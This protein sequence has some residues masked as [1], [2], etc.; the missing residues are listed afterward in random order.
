[1]FKLFYYI[2]RK[3]QKYLKRIEAPVKMCIKLSIQIKPIAKVAICLGLRRPMHIWDAVTS[4]WHSLRENP[5]LSSSPERQLNAPDK[6]STGSKQCQIN[7]C[8]FCG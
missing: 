4:Y 8:S 6:Q 7:I 5:H 3:L 2:I 1:M